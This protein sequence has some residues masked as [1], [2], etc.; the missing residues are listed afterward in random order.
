VGDHTGDEGRQVISA[1]AE[2]G[3]CSTMTLN[4]WRASDPIGLTGSLDG[5]A[6]VLLVGQVE[7]DR[8]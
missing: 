8:S 1:L 6:F 4:R 5:R 2:Y 7:E 3:S